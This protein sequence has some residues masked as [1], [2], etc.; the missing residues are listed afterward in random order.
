MNREIIVQPV[1]YVDPNLIFDAPLAPAGTTDYLMTFFSTPV[2]EQMSPGGQP[3][4]ERCGGLQI[5]ALHQGK[6]G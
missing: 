1:A 6:P 4:D 5:K 3:P 2:A